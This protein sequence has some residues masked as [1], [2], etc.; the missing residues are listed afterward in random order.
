M[1][2]KRLLIIGAVVAL[3]FGG[4]LFLLTSMRRS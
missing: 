3:F 1:V 2:N 4:G